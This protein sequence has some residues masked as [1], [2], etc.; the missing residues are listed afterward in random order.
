MLTAEQT[1]ANSAPGP[2]SVR[3][4]AFLN[5][6]SRTASQDTWNVHSGPIGNFGGSVDFSNNYGDVDDDRTIKP[7]GRTSWVGFT[8]IY[9]L[10]ALIP[11][12]GARADAEFRALG[13]EDY[14]AD[15]LYDSVTVG[16]GQQAT[17]STRCSPGPRKARSSTTTRMAGSAT[18]GWRSTGAGSAGS[19]TRS[20]GCCGSCSR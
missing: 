1:V 11:Q 9:W 14:R 17:T 15:L 18:S 20:S 19:C 2:I 3:P 8:D 16:P 10:S 7:E 6:T 4:Y 12:Q 13:R 5:R